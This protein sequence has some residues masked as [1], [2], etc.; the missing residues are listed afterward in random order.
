MLNVFVFLVCSFLC[1]CFSFMV[2]CLLSKGF[3]IPY[4][5]YYFVDVRVLQVTITQDLDIS[6]SGLFFYDCLSVI[7]VIISNLIL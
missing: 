2:H 3:Y 7:E 4:P 1:V 6:V 5:F